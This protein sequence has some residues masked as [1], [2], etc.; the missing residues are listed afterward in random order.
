MRIRTK[1]GESAGLV[2]WERKGA[3]PEKRGGLL[4]GD[5]R[6]GF[7]LNA[8]ADLGGRAQIARINVP[9]RLLC[10]ADMV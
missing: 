6:V 8:I 5:D 4:W 10:T 9:L 2:P 3:K 7:R 1:G